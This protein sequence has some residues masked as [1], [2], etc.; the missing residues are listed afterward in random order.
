MRASPISM[1]LKQERGAL[2]AESVKAKHNVKV[3]RAI[4]IE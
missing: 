1:L 4:R 2:A 3:F